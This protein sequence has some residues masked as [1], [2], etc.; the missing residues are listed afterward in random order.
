MKLLGFDITWAATR[1]SAVSPISGAPGSG[2]ALLST[3]H[4]HEPFTGAWQR[5]IGAHPQNVLAHCAVFACIDLITGD[6]GKLASDGI[7]LL[8]RGASGIWD[9]VQ[10]PAYSKVLREPNRY[11][12]SI[13]FVTA[14]EISKAI[15]GNT[16]V[17][18][19]RD[20]RGVVQ[21]LYI[22]D[23]RRVRPLVAPDGAIYYNVGADNLAGIDVSVQIPQSEIIHDIGF[24]PWHHLCGV[25][26]IIA[27]ALPACHGLRIQEHSERFF[28]N[29]ASPSGILT[30]PG[31]I[32]QETADRLKKEWETRFSGQNVGRVW[33]AGDGLEFKKMAM[34]SVEGQLIE[35]LKWTAEQVCT[36]FH[37]PP[38]M[39][40]IG[41]LPSYNNVQALTQMY[42]S[43]CLQKLIETFERCLGNGLG[44]ATDL[45]IHLDL[46]ALLQM[47]TV[48]KVA[49]SVAGIQGGLFETNKQRKKFNL[50]PLEGGDT[51]Y[52][53]QQQ[54]SL[55]A[56]AKR[57]AREDPFA[58]S[59]PEPANDP[60]DDG[61]EDE[62]DEG[63]DE[64]D[65][66]TMLGEIQKGYDE[67]R[68]A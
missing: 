17:L 52:L 66:R 47:D 2:W 58:T 3:S 38:F 18:K 28:M 27:C 24:T 23:G 45:K 5:N 56:L 34:T 26:P 1:K 65:E 59:Q 31:F 29:A 7:Q 67:Q 6:I 57:D 37:V 60:G 61:G 10:N 43:Q 11:Q 16:Y 41:P 54:Y 8:Q 40:G 22:L 64:Q 46:E 25:S 32:N 19:E 39:I 44:L 4:V 35:Q 53:Q 9:E 33:V 21:A 30:A 51:V 49:A 12:N 62:A 63:E 50:G 20:E 48:T 42:Y 13:Q 15:Y 36:A 68:A 55:A 14:W